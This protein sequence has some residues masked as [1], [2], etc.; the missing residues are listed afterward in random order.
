MTIKQR[1][2]LLAYLGYYVGEIDGVF[3][4]GSRE[5]TKDFQRDFFQDESKADGIC[6][7]ETEQALTHS[8]AYGMP[9]RKVAE[10]TSGGF[11]ADIKHFDRKEF[12][13]KCGN[14]HC[15]GYPA[16]PQEKLVRVADRVREHFGATAT[17]SSGLRCTKHNANV[18]GVS[19]SR[20]LTGKA[21]DFCIRGKTSAQVLEYVQKQTDIRYAYAIDSQFVHMDIL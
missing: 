19:N 8:V 3:G 7:S 21:M 12:K 6:G 9:A 18:G 16:E 14:I 17:V 5:A 1:Q 20:H 4:S 15:N 13:C 10:T 11:W 2:H